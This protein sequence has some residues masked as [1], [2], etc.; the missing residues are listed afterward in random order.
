M[1]NIE[2]IEK[3]LSILESLHG[4]EKRRNRRAATLRLDENDDT[5]ESTDGMTF[6]FSTDISNAI[7]FTIFFKSK[8][9][10]SIEDL[11]VT[12]DGLDALTRASVAGEN[13]VG[14]TG[15]ATKSEGVLKVKFKSEG[16]V[17]DVRIEVRGIV[18]RAER[19]TRVETLS[20]GGK[21]YAFLYDGFKRES[22][23]Y[24]AEGSVLVL[25]Q[26]IENTCGCA[27]AVFDDEMLLAVIE[28]GGLGVYAYDAVDNL[29]T[30]KWLL[31]SFPENIT[32][33]EGFY[34]VEKGKVYEYAEREGELTAIACG[35]AGKE[36]I[37]SYLAPDDYIVV[38]FDGAGTY[39]S[40]NGKTYLSKGENFHVGEGEK[41]YFAEEDVI[42]EVDCRTGKRSAKV[43][44]EE[45]A[46]ITYGY[47]TRRGC[48]LVYKAY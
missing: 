8:V 38:G 19:G 48:S 47:V 37:R 26:R 46:P 23:L 18:R 32:G 11:E 25:K 41:A 28:N 31:E 2:D 9:N 42:Y 12:Y 29:V 3:R 45:Y 44:A 4:G 36:I 1:N 39:V 7:D 14:F 34:G 27:I 10:S 24:K 15:V 35:V 16:N 43:Y 20:F 13:R 40:K 6:R 17:S 22:R 5:G 33:G 30:K 21:D